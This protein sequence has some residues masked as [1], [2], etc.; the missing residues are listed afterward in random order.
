MAK[1]LVTPRR[2]KR[3]YRSWRRIAFGRTVYAYVGGNPL[4]YID[5]LGLELCQVNLNGRADQ[6]DTNFSPLVQAWNTLNLA[7][8]IT[9]SFTSAFRS[10][11]AQGGLNSTNA[12]TPAPAGNSL[13]E[14]GYAVDIS[15]NSLTATQRT[16]VRAN[17]TAAG[18]SWGGN[19]SRPDKV[20]F[21]FDPGNRATLIQSAQEANDNGSSNQCTCDG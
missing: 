20:H 19:F 2:I 13:H 15:W 9:V 4:K 1:T 14:A 21:F 12:I 5:P 8:G 18:L 17:A 16:T 3:N 11:A 6:L 10:T 7:D